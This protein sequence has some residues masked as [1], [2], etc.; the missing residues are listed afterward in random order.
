MLQK[1]EDERRGNLIRCVCNAEIEEREGDFDRITCN[2]LELV[3]MAQG[4][5]TLGDFCHH[6]R[7]NLDNN[8]LLTSLKKRGCQ[9]ARS[10]SNLENDIRRLDTRFFDNLLYD[11]RVLEDMLTK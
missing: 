3:G 7:I 11:K 2:H 8:D 4:L 6:A 5:H 10:R 1:L 9:V